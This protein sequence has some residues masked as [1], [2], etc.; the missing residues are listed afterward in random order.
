[1]EG[2][3]G[4]ER[5]GMEEVD[6]VSVGLGREE[7]MMMSERKFVNKEENSIWMIAER[8]MNRMSCVPVLKESTNH[9]K[10]KLEFPAKDRRFSRHSAAIRTDRLSTHKFT[11]PPINLQPS[12]GS[13]KSTIRESTIRPVFVP[14]LDE[15]KLGAPI[16]VRPKVKSK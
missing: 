4:F 7:E 8:K 9:P 15:L 16:L 11:L 2:D 10:A 3:V 13:P 6:R 5:V 1:M 12:H 14:L